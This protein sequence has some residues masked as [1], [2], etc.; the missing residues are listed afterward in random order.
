MII[1]GFRLLYVN[2]RYCAVYDWSVRK[3]MTSLAY[4]SV[5]IFT[6]IAVLTMPCIN[7]AV[8]IKYLN[9]NDNM[10][11]E[12]CYKRSSLICWWL[13]NLLL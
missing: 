3:Y 11:L 6:V 5:A 10:A 7:D 13:V 1:A 9:E 8:S 4:Y 12:G 2:S